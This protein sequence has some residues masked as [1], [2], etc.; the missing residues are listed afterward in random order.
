MAPAPADVKASLDAILLEF[1]D[2]ASVAET[3]LRLRELAAKLRFS[4]PL[5]TEVVKRAISM[6]ADKPQ[7]AQEMLAALV[8]SLAVR[9][10][11]SSHD[12][13][14]AADIILGRLADLQLDNPSAA[15]VVAR[16]LAYL[17][18]EDVLSE[19]AWGFGV[20]LEGG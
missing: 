4:V 3:L 17:V 13:T 19:G 16:F 12:I 18:Q 6:A 15:Q 8:A 2:S 1:L 9:G 10:A 11:V 20:G 5:G 7:A 14:A